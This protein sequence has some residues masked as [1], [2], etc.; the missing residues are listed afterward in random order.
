MN[1]HRILII[2]LCIGALI[3]C[4]DESS[5]F[6]LAHTFVKFYGDV[7]TNSGIKALPTADGGYIVLGE[8]IF[9]DTATSA[10]LFKTNQFGNEE[11]SL[12]IDEDNLNSAKDMLIDDDGSYLIL[13]DGF[14]L[15][16]GNQR[17]F[18]IKLVRVSPTGTVVG[19]EIFDSDGLGTYEEKG[20]GITKAADGGYFIIGSTNNTAGGD[21]DMYV[22]RLDD[23][24]NVL[25]DKV[26]GNVNGLEDIGTNL[27]EDA[28][29][30]LIWLGTEQVNATNTRVRMVKTNSLGNILWDFNYPVVENNTIVNGKS[31]SGGLISLNNG[32]VF[33]GSHS[34]RGVILA[35]VDGDGAQQWFR[36]FSQN[37]GAEGRALALGTDN[38]LLIAGKTSGTEASNMMLLKTD[39]QGLFIW[40]NTFG[41]TGINA[42]NSVAA[43]PDGGIIIAGDGAFDANQMMNLIK[44]TQD[45]ITSE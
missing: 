40:S 44:T 35:K 8:T 24:L 37:M 14:E 13:V 39:I 38:T 31:A 41:S 33:T 18:D 42:A 9:G 21:L 4:D 28:T 30:N 27:L 23:A 3:S 17:N 34:S 25:W 16:A 45:G 12:V 20:N 19:T 43:T 1:I 2:I 11:W 10:H 15:T 6:G 36:Q 29:G 5:D 26:Y 22:L 32:Y 7:N